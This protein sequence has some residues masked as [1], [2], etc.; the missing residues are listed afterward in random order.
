MFKFILNVTL[1]ATSMFSYANNVSPNNAVIVPQQDTKFA[2]NFNFTY[3]GNSTSN[4]AVGFYMLKVFVNP[5]ISY[6]AKICQVDDSS[7]CTNLKIYTN[8][9][10][11]NVTDVQ[12]MDLAFGHS[13]LFIPSSNYQLLSNG[14]YSVTISNISNPPKNITAMPQSWFIYYLDNKK[15]LLFKDINYIN[16]ANNPDKDAQIAQAIIQNNLRQSKPINVVT[17]IIPKP[18][19]V[20]YYP[21]NVKINKD[22]IIKSDF[23]NVTFIST[24]LNYIAHPSLGSTKLNIHSC[25]QANPVCKLIYDQNPEGYVLTFL[26]NQIDIYA[27]NTAGVFYASQSITQLMNH[28]LDQIPNQVIV[29]YPHYKYRGLMLDVVR[30]FFTVDQVKQVIDVMAAHKLNTLHLHLADD[31]AFRL[32]LP[33]FPKLIQYASSRYL[34]HFVGPTNFIDPN[35]ING[36]LDRVDRPYSGFY[37][38]AQMQDLIKYAN[39]R[40]ITII[41]EIEMP[42][43]ARSLKKAY[44][45]LFFDFANPTNYYNVQGYNDNVLPAYL[46]NKNDKFTQAINQLIT[47]VANQF[48]NQTTLYAINNEISLSADEVPDGAYGK[49]YDPVQISHNFFENISQ[50]LDTYKLSGW[51]QL[52]QAPD[53]SIGDKVVSP[54]YSGHLWAWEPTNKNGITMAQNL[55]DNNYPTVIDFADYNYFDIMQSP[56]YEQPGLYWAAPYIDSAKVLKLADILNK[57]QNNNQILGVE[58]CLWSELIPTDRQM[59]YMLM[60]RLSALSEVAWSDPYNLSWIGLDKNLGKVESR[61]FTQYLANRFGVKY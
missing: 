59:W 44:P 56:Q 24:A 45:E 17:P 55:I 43:H 36:S 39:S 25:D 7:N 54:K 52:V 49:D 48:T 35:I 4:W 47:E 30:H 31:E 42:S 8:P 1:I 29:D 33:S 18:Q 6:D 9:L 57:M 53:G 28:Y 58:A 41:P 3:S 38:M 15:V 51:Q 23:N 37:T 11:K 12:K 61:G 34:G 20:G 5:Q 32:Q 10:P 14:R 27:Y 2:I 26:N 22:I 21:G 50:N 46:Y 19:V 60:P 40:F 16:L 13:A